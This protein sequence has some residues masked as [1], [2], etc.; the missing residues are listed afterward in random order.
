M[1]DSLNIDHEVKD[2][3]ADMQ[4]RVPSDDTVLDT[5]IDS[6]DSLRVC[7]RHHQ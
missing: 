5:F 2:S 3:S 1:R 6:S 4:V 7:E